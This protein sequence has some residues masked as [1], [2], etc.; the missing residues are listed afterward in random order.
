MDIISLVSVSYT[1]LVKRILTVK[2]EL[3]FID[4][5]SLAYADKTLLSQ[6]GSQQHRTVAREAVR[7]SLTLLK[8]TET[9]NGSTL[10][11]DLK[12][13]KKIAVAGISADDIGIQCGG[14]T[15]TWQGSTGNI[16]TV[17]YTHLLV[18]LFQDDNYQQSYI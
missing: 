2:F 5:P 7:K 12:K 15:M 1:H 8:N 4:N 13:M 14:W 16:T 3:N 6:F 17:S 18:S 11:L 10:M 9:A